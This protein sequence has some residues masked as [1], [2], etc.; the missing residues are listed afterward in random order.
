MVKKKNS[1]LTYNII[2]LNKLCATEKRVVLL[3]FM[4]MVLTLSVWVFCYENAVFNIVFGLCM[5][6]FHCI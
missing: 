3:E 2:L 4:Y 5:S 1:F 6:F